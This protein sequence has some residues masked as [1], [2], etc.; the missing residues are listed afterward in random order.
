MS[1]SEHLDPRQI[2]L[3]RASIRH[4]LSWINQQ[5]PIAV[6]LALEELA[7]ELRLNYAKSK[8]GET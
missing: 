4:S 8:K 5:H 7:Q 3:I 1:P 2:A 6:A